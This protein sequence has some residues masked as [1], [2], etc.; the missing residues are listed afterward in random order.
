MDSLATPVAKTLT[1]SSITF[2]PV[3][4]SEVGIHTITVNLLDD[5]NDFDS[6][7]FKVTVY[8]SAP[9]FT[10]LPLAN[11]TVPLNTKL[12]IPIQGFADPEGNP[13]TMIFQEVR[14][15]FNYALSGYQSQPSPYTL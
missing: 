1:P 2:S 11:Y 8:N 9:Y 12:K 4:F 10:N 5:A 3:S 14:S 6:K 15:G 7:Q 13:I